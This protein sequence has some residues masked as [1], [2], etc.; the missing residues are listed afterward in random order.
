MKCIVLK[1][2]NGKKYNYYYDICEF[3]SS[4]KNKIE[5]HLGIKKE[6]I[7]LLYKGQLLNNDYYLNIPDNS[8][9]HL[10]L[11]LATIYE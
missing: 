8:V 1:F 2:Q 10:V 4:F 11:Q 5:E 6:T 9:I 3:V 7:R